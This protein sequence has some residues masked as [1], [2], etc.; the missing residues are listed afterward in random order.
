M[1]T[2]MRRCAAQGLQEGDS[3]T[4]SRTFTR[5]D[6]RLMGDVTRDYNPV[7]YEPSWAKSKGFQAEICHG[8][9]VGGMICEIGG[10]LAW[11][12]TGM[13]FR[14]LKPVYFGETITC[15][16]TITKL[17]ETGRAQAEAEM[18]NQ[19]GQKV[20]LATLGGRV[21]CGEEK[22]VLHQILEQGDQENKLA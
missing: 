8:L 2:Q 19:E 16:M 3:F 14:F 7:H 15:K 17:D 18:Y 20:C 6:T 13:D 10:Q 12:A 1:S 22:E 11:L 21:P 4:I 9:L 5:E